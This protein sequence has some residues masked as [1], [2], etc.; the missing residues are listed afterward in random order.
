MAVE[1]VQPAANAVSISHGTTQTSQSLAFV[2]E[3]FLDDWHYRI[4]S[5]TLAERWQSK[6]TLSSALSLLK[7]HGVDLKPEEESQLMTLTDEEVIDKLVEKVPAQNNEHFKVFFLQLQLVVE[8]VSRLRKALEDG[9]ADAV[10]A[11][12]D[13]AESAG[14]LQYILRQTVVSTGQ[15]L[16]ALKAKHTGWLKDTEA[17]MARMLRAHQEAMAS[18]HR[19]QEA[20]E[21]LKN[22]GAVQRRKAYSVLTAVANDRDVELLKVSFGGWQMA[23]QNEKSEAKT[24]SQYESLLE[25]SNTKMQELRVKQLSSVSGVMQKKGGEHVRQL[26]GDVFLIWQQD[27]KDVIV[28]RKAQERID[29]MQLS[30]VKVAKQVMERMT[31]AAGLDLCKLCLTSWTEEI[32]EAKRQ[33]TLQAGQ[34][35]MENKLKS[36]INERK[37]NAQSV[38]TQLN[39]ATNNDLL[40][41][42][43]WLWQMRI[44]EERRYLQVVNK[45]SDLNKSTKE[46]SHRTLEAAVF[47]MSRVV[48]NF[49]TMRLLR[50][51]SAWTAVAR[52][53]RIKHFYDNKID[54]K[55]HQLQSVQNLFREFAGRLE[56]GLV[57]SPR[58]DI[59]TRG[60]YKSDGGV[61]L[62]ELGPST[63]QGYQSSNGRPP[64]APLRRDSNSASQSSIRRDRP[65]TAGG[66]PS[67]S[68]R[69]PPQPVRD[70]SP[71]V[72]RLQDRG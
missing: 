18:K 61:I 5:S 14:V 47:V 19:L 32:G 43:F 60:V 37:A 59:N 45:L 41:D 51:F 17:K 53:E 57:K 62:P 64:T 30:Q 39:T 33:R 35:D 52:M 58:D 8:T 4:L 50:C 56:T 22:M 48:A 20:Q 26:V 69:Q 44:L 36:V 40:S 67:M 34:L 1:V 46:I 7:H 38:L 49:D 29:T 66:T 27:T 6:K 12:I 54:T 15:E 24:R 2:L 25:E 71:G 31:G 16:V 65:Q 72:D 42:L 55:R 68:L 23:I 3:Q 28:H 21:A 13:D 70:D 10:E 9:Q 11:A 63:A